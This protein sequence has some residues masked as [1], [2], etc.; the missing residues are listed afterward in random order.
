[1]IYPFQDLLATILNDPP[2]N[3]A[4]NGKGIITQVGNFIGKRCVP[5][6]RWWEWLSD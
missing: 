1:M 3:I 6:N 2:E 4:T 5:F